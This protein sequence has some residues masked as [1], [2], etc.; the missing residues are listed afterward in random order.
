MP[1]SARL[2]AIQGP[3]QLPPGGVAAAQT[4]GGAPQPWYSPLAAALFA[5]VALLSPAHKLQLLDGVQQSPDRLEIICDRNLTGRDPMVVGL[6]DIVHLYGNVSLAAP[7]AYV[8]SLSFVL[9]FFWGV[10]CRSLISPF[11]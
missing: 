11:A 8:S 9:T 10:W 4:S 7:V 1:R 6:R 2:L 5:L 3:L